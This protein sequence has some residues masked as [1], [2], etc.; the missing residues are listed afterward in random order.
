MTIYYKIKIC[1]LTLLIRVTLQCYIT[2]MTAPNPPLTR[3]MVQSLPS[4]M[5][6]GPLRDFSVLTQSQ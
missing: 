5:D 1:V 4:D 3:S 2:S 6:P